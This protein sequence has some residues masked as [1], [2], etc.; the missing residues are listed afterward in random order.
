MSEAD[1]VFETWWCLWAGL[2]FIFGKLHLFIFPF[3]LASLNVNLETTRAVLAA[4]DVA[5]KRLGP[6]DVVTRF[7]LNIS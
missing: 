2:S 7:L 1:H 5:D 4:A 3:F 6:L